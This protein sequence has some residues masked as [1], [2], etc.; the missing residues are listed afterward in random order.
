MKKILIRYSLLII[1]AFLSQACN[2]NHKADFQE[3]EQAEFIQTPNGEIVRFTED[4]DFS[5]ST[6]LNKKFG[7]ERL[8]VSKGQYDILTSKSDFGT[9]TLKI[10]EYKIL[11]SNTATTSDIQT[12]SDIQDYN[13]IGIRIAKVKKRTCGGEPVSCKCCCGIGFR[14]GIAGLS[15]SDEFDDEEEFQ[16]NNIGNISSRPSDPRIK[17]A[18]I[19]INL[20]DKTI[21]I[22]FLEKINW[23]SLN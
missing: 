1:V 4:E 13:S 19:F 22:H 8:V 15:E 14:C 17:R 16:I 18:Q 23:R 5:F 21:T 20:V 3:M 10:K 7:F 2:K 11:N 12:N 6:F 9:V